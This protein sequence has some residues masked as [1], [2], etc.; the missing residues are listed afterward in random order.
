VG[1]IDDYSR[2][3]AEGKTAL[4]AIRQGM[5]RI[6]PH[7]NAR[8]TVSVCTM[9]CGAVSFSVL[10]KREHVFSDTAYPVVTA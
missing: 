4:D 2:Q 5:V 8:T 1:L 7:L 3:P 6:T 9:L 10:A